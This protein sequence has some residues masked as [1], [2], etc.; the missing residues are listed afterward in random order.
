[1]D[2]D[3]YRRLSTLRRS[4]GMAPVYPSVRPLAPLTGEEAERLTKASEEEG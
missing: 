2:Q 1:M 4:F 3:E